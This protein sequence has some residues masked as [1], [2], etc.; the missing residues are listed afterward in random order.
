[1][2]RGGRMKTSLLRDLRVGARRMGRRPT[3]AI[4][5]PAV[6]ALG[7]AGHD[8]YLQRRESDLPGPAAGRPTGAA[9]RALQQQRAGHGR[10]RRAARLPAPIQG[11]PPRPPLRRPRPRPR[12]SLKLPP[13]PCDT[14]HEAQPL[15]G[16]V[17]CRRGGP[18]AGDGF[19]VR[20]AAE[21]RPAPEDSFA[22]AGA[23]ALH[24]APEELGYLAAIR[25]RVELV[26]AR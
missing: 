7:I 3:L 17:N 9:G 26:P 8:G 10:R 13:S 14:Q 1:M 15:G 4:V 20:V 21:D 23:P 5:A 11:A 2:T 16:R 6:L 12:C 25:S 18:L 19:V 22:T 24:D